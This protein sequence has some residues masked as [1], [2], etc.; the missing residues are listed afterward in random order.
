MSNMQK[1]MTNNV[2]DYYKILQVTHRANG[3]ELK[4]TYGKLAMKEA[5]DVLAHSVKRQSYCDIGQTSH[6]NKSCYNNKKAN[7]K[8]STTTT[9]RKRKASNSGSDAPLKYQKVVLENRNEHKLVFS[10]GDLYKGAK[11]TLKIERKVLDG[12][13][14]YV[15]I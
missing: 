4:M 1:N 3:E 5:Y 7:N 10:L 12:K 13:T 6:V 15:M 8:A 9:T 11:R 2:V 14:G